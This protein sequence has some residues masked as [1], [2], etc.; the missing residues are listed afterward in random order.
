MDSQTMSSF[1]HQQTT[2]ILPDKLP[3]ITM[4]SAFDE[5]KPGTTMT[6]ECASDH[7]H[8]QQQSVQEDDL[9]HRQYSSTSSFLPALPSSSTP[10]DVAC[11]YQPAPGLYQNAVSPPLTPAVS[12]SSVLLESMQF[13][14][15]YSVDVGPFSFSSMSHQQQQHDQVDDPYR[16]SSTTAMEDAAAAYSAPTSS[17]ANYAFMPAAPTG[18]ENDAMMGNTSNDKQR[19]NSRSQL[20]QGPTTKHKHVCKYAYCGWSFKRYEHLKRH[21]LVHTGERPHVCHFPGCG[22]S[23]SRSD[24]FH[25]HY[26]TH[27]KKSMMQQ[28]RR[29][30]QQHTLGNDHTS[31]NIAAQAAAAAASQAQQR[32]HHHHHSQQQQQQQHHHHHHHHHHEQQQQQQ[33]FDPSRNG[34]FSN[35]SY[36]DMY[37][38]RQYTEMHGDYQQQYMRPFMAT[39]LASN[40]FGPPATPTSPSGASSLLNHEAQTFYSTTADGRPHSPYTTSTTATSYPAMNASPTSTS[41]PYATGSA[42]HNNG[43]HT[44]MSTTANTRRSSSASSTSSSGQQQQKSHVCPMPACQRRFKRLEHLK[45]HMRIHTLERPFGCTFPNCQKTFSRSDNLSQHMKTHQRHEDRRRRQQQQQQHQ[46]QHQQQQQ[47]H[48]QQHESYSSTP[49][50]PTH[51]H[52]PPL[53]PSSQTG[54]NNNSNNTMAAAAAAAAA[55]ASMGMNWHPTNAGTVGC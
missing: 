24:N 7:Q 21:M 23:F 47:Q 12:P 14:R 49:S 29:A 3:S 34:Y 8:Q 6:N 37:D 41:Y 17:R 51:H 45:R 43:S 44:N 33:G 42:N 31:P 25:A 50:Q 36:P 35:P 54:N 52:L 18:M 5:T 26:R 13:K 32:Q 20:T 55:V 10:Q 38:H 15:K 11:T 39:R 9:Y 2:P 19:R 1:E 4:L 46:H 28:S 48:Q 22:K 53:H 27:T 30:S 16:R 40:Q